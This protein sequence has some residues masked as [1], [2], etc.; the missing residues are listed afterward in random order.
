[1]ATQYYEVTIKNRRR[2]VKVYKTFKAALAYYEKHAQG[3][4][5]ASLTEVHEDGF[6]RFIRLN[7]RGH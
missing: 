3:A 7:S 5:Y 2:S 1:M 4:Q 6:G